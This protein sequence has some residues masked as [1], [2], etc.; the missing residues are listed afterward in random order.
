MS[1]ISEPLAVRLDPESWIF[2]NVDPDHMLKAMAEILLL[3]AIEERADELLFDMDGGRVR[4][5]IRV[6]DEL[7]A[8][9]RPPRS[10]A[11]S[12]LEH[13]GTLFGTSESSETASAVVQLGSGTVMVNY[14]EP[15]DQNSLY[16]R[17]SFMDSSIDPSSAESVITNSFVAR[18]RTVPWC[19]RIR[20]AMFGWL[21]R[22]ASVDYDEIL[23]R[24]GE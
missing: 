20:E 21:P 18:R 6:A 4:C 11:Q 7:R 16:A 13:Y 17:L 24:Y 1:P 2:R 10:A 12:M 14:T 9:P 15:G 22:A 3:M 23:D 8:L 19:R 5:T